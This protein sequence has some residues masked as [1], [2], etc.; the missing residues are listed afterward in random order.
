M[1]RAALALCLILAAPAIAQQAS[2]SPGWFD[3]LLGT[4]TAESDVEQGSRLERLIQD[5]LSDAGR[6]VTVRGFEGA[7]SGQATL[8]S[9]TIADDE[10]IWLTLEDAVLDWNRAALLRGRLE[11]TELTAARILLPRLAASSETDAP[12]PEATPFQLPEL[13]V[14]IEINRIAAENVQIGAPV[15]GAEAQ[16]SLDGALSLVSGDGAANLAI[17]RRDGIGALRLE[18]SYGNA[19][20]QLALNFS[21]Q[22]A[23]DGIF[24]NL[25]G[26]PGAPSIDFSVTGDAPVTDFT[27]NIRLATDGADRLSGTIS[28]N[29]TED[30]TQRIL[31]D[32]GGD[33]A[34]ILAPAYQPFFGDAIDLV[35]EARIAPTGEISVPEFQLNAE[36]I[37]LFGALELGSDRLPRKI[38]V[39]G[40]ISSEDGT[41]V[42]LPIAGA[43]TRIDR[44]E[45]DLDFDANTSQNWTGKINLT[46]LDREGL[47]ADQLALSGSGRIASGAEPS[48]TAELTFDARQLETGIP[49]VTEA[50]GPDLNG[51]ANIDWTGGPLAIK[52]LQLNGKAL[53][54]SGDANITTKETGP[55]ITGALNIVADQLA[56]FSTLAGRSIG[57]QATLETTFELSPLSG[58]FGIDATGQTRDLTLDNAQ[59]DAI[60]A[61]PTNLDL[62]A[63]RDENGFRVRLNQLASDMAQITGQ[64]DLRSGGSTAKFEAKLADTSVLVATL[65]G[66]SSLSFDGQEDENRDW[67]IVANLAGPT[68]QTDLDGKLSNLYELPAFAGHI[69][70]SADDLSAFADF[71]NRPLTGSIGIDATGSLTADLLD[72]AL[73]AD[74]SGSNLSLGQAEADRL[75]EGDLTATIDVTRDGDVIN[76]TQLDLSTALLQ[77]SASGL[78]S[79]GESTATVE[80]TLAET[81]A[82][83]P[84]LNGPSSLSFS[85]QEDTNRDWTILANLAGPTFQTTLDGTLSN[86][87]EVPAFEGEINANADDLSAF[88]DLAN[89]PLQGSLKLDATGNATADLMKLALKADVSGAGLSIGQAEADRLLAGNLTATIDATRDG[90]VIDIA[91]LD[92]ST[93][94]LQASASGSLSENDTQLAISA[95]LANIAGFVDGLSGP[96]SVDGTVARQDGTFL[97]DLNATGPGGARADVSGTVDQDLSQ[98]NLQAEGAVPLGLAN[99]FIQPRSLAG[100]AAFNLGLNGALQLQNL[101]GQIT[102][103]GTRLA[104]PALGVALND[105]TGTVSLAQGSARLDLNTAVEGGGRIAI[106]GPIAMAAPNTAQL[107]IDLTR[108]ALSDPRLYETTADGRISVT[109]PLAGGAAISGAIELGQTDIRIPESGFGGAGDV[110]EIIHLNEAPPVRSTRRRAGLLDSASTSQSTGPAFPIDIRVTA[111]NRIFVRGR[112]LDSEFGGGLRLTNTTADIVPL[113]AFELIRGRL[114]ILGRRLQLEEARITMQGSFTPYIR[115]SASTE[116]EDYQVNVN[117]IGPVDNPEISFTSAP[118]LP[119]EEVLSRLIFGRG[120]ETLSPLQ[121]A[122]L[123]L[124]IRT[125]A[126]QGGEGIVG[127]IRDQA[128][129]AD[130]DVT[131]TE[132]GNAAVRAGAYLGENIYTDVTVDSAGETELNLNLDITPSLKARGGVTNAGDTSVGIFFERDY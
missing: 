29:K 132:D 83:V 96:A 86:L 45:L 115:L 44:A 43:P 53:S 82:L 128:G 31:A 40:Q 77:A 20:E 57:G 60:L 10:G 21:L 84:A 52:G 19:S 97:L 89:M 5:Q 131:T 26:L 9:L 125:L 74:V 61:G 100:T 87:Y 55:T 67:T 126:G 66:P 22:E 78:L 91:E 103:N 107:Q 71:A 2:E 68:F 81:S 99:R 122:R 33:I 51:A 120:L 104:A 4:D 62:T 69:D 14:S 121:A 63:T 70:A 48:V 41:P 24:V 46:G 54:A 90:N 109:G 11:V 38:A 112:G 80:A 13:P 124:A 130:L 72:L 75:L 39:T 56:D 123:A 37:S 106:Q 18:A 127:K 65:N 110:P 113:G 6:S 79:E 12:T 114:D 88:A 27:A 30:E 92:L 15:F 25:V 34:P 111:P 102:T 129:L 47:T 35:A 73:K 108:I 76:I 23:E 93:A 42:L 64:A 118:E 50:I 32:I 7:L 1:R 17:E 36:A 3:R 16:V 116:A 105:I 59:A 85:G 117:I 98:A 8:E 58:A 119:Q 101:T 49:G 28:L 95:N 94:L